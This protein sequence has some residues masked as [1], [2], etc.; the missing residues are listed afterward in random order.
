MKKQPCLRVFLCLAENE[1]TEHIQDPG[2]SPPGM[3]GTL[4]CLPASVRTISCVGAGNL[5]PNNFIETVKFLKMGH[6]CYQR[7]I[8]H[9][10]NFSI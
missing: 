1:P 6:F 2:Q 10:I 7:R 9:P 3:G 5:I 8:M 4:A